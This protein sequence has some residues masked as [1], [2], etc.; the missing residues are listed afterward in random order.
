MFYAAILKRA[1]LST[2][3][4]KSARQQVETKLGCDLLSR[5]KEI[6]GIVM[7]YVSQNQVEDNG[8]RNDNIKISSEKLRDEIEG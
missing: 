5:K 6:D 2:M 8:D 4:S 1:D 3:T 7:A